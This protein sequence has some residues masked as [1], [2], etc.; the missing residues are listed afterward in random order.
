[1]GSSHLKIQAVAA[2]G[3]RERRAQCQ[4]PVSAQRRFGE[5][6]GRRYRRVDV[7]VDKSPKTDS[8]DCCLLQRVKKSG[9]SAH[10]IA[11]KGEKYGWKTPD[12]SP[13]RRRLEQHI[14]PA[15]SPP[16]RRRPE[17]RPT[18]LSAYRLSGRATVFALLPLPDW[19]TAAQRH[20]GAISNI[21]VER[22]EGRGVEGR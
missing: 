1:M 10:W 19:L 9:R 7:E 13:T 5:K 17:E 2:P 11:G 15:G 16:S 8:H 3:R 20:S 6:R 14:T 21:G 12:V 4:R 18:P 22:R